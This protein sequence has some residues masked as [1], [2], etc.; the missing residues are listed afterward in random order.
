MEGLAS[1]LISQRGACRPVK[2]GNHNFGAFFGKPPNVRFSSPSPTVKTCYQK[3]QIRGTMKT[4]TTKN[5]ISSGKPSF[6]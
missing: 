4:E 5:Q 3:R 2:L 6:Q 1:K